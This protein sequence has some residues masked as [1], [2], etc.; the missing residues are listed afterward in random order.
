MPDPPDPPIARDAYEQLAAG[1]DREGQTKPS[2]A[3]LERPATLSLF[4]DVDETRVLDAGCGAGHLS[5]EL[6]DRGANVVG[7]D[8]SNEMLTYA[9]Q[10]VPA[11]EFGQADLGKG[12]PFSDARFD[13]WLVVSVQHPHADF[14][15]YEHSENYHEIERVSA[16]WES[17]GEEVDVPAFRRPLAAMLDPALAA[18]FRLDRLVEPTPTDEFRDARPERYEY[19]STHPNFLC[20]RFEVSV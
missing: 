15:E 16:T 2:N 14:E 17:F 8:L 6:T 11:A 5:R 10:R 3:Y 1:Y 12:L 7:L 20:L 18:G 9:R 4:P 19:E 13:G